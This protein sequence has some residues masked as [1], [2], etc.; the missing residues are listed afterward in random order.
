MQQ[1]TGLDA[2]QLLD[3]YYTLD[4][5]EQWDVSDA[6]GMEEVQVYTGNIGDCLLYT[7]LFMQRGKG[8]CPQSRREVRF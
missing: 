4:G 8:W 2:Q 6:A 1:V 5:A 7:S 3:T